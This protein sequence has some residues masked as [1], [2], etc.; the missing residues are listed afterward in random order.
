MGKNIHEKPWFKSGRS[1]G[2]HC[3]DEEAQVIKKALPHAE[4]RLFKQAFN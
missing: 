2:L 1:E 3:V 4:E